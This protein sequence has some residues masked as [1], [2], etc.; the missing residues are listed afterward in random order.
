MMNI[1]VVLRVLL[2]RFIYLFFDCHIR[3]S[4]DVNRTARLFSALKKIGKT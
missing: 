1:F 4:G 2:N 3:L